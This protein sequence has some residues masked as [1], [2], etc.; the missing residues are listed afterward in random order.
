M[1][2]PRKIPGILIY[3]L[4][5]FFS[6]IGFVYALHAS[7]TQGNQTVYAGGSNSKD[8]VE[9]SKNLEETELENYFDITLTVKTQT[10]IEEI[11][12]AQ[13]IAV[14]I[15]MDISNTMD[16]KWDDNG[17]STPRIDTAQ[18]SAIDFLAEFKTAAAAAPTAAR[19]V[20]F[21][22]FNRSAYEVFGLSDC[23][24]DTQFNN[25]SQK[26]KAIDT[27]DSSNVF[28]TNMEAGLARADKMLEETEIKNKYIIFITDG[29]PTTYSTEIGGT[30]GY[31][32]GTSVGNVT[33]EAQD[34]IFYNYE[35]PS[36]V[37]SGTNYSDRATSRAEEQALKIRNKGITIYSIGIGMTNRQTMQELIE[38][39]YYILDTDT[40]ENNWEY[41][42]NESP[43]KV[44]R[45]YGI[46]PGVTKKYEECNDTEKNS[47]YNNTTYYKTWL[48]DY[49]GSG[50]YYDS[51]AGAQLAQAYKDIFADIKEMSEESSQAT[52]VA[53]D[54]MGVDGTVESIEFVGFLD[55]TNALQN[56]LNIKNENQSDTATISNNKINWDLKN[57]KYEPST[58]EDNITYYTYE[59]KYRV[60]IQNELDAFNLTRVYD[61]NGK[62]TLTYVTRNNGVL[63]D[64]KEIDF[65]IPSV[66]A[67][68]GELEFTKK[69]ASFDVIESGALAGAEFTL[70][71]SSNCPCLVETMTNH[72]HMSEDQSYTATSGTD[73]K[74]SFEN[75]PSGHKY[76]LKEVIAPDNYIASSKQYSVTVAYGETTGGPDDG[77][78]ENTIQKGNLKISKEVQGNKGYKGE[79][80]FKIVI[81][82]NNTTLTG[83][84]NY[85]LY[86]A[87]TKK[88]TTG[89]L[90][91]TDTFKLKDGDYIIIEG[92]PIGSKYKITELTTNGYTVKNKINDGDTQTGATASCSSD[93][94]SINN[95]GTQTVEFYNIAGYILPATGN[96]GMLILLIIVA[97][98]LIVPIINIGYMFYKNRKEDK[99][100]S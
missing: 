45:Y 94:C 100:T 22:T 64:N 42:S 29:L 76:I 27:P 40:E 54:P 11:M 14:V 8:G 2:Q 15:V 36:Y 65:P 41:Y 10:K 32:P 55:D 4:I 1:K 12:K 60:R 35:H 99:L 93:S 31:Y 96:S 51:D 13:D 92:L 53:E 34:G 44:G 57:S 72:K 85:T 66:V 68:L 16:S 9:V 48:R 25:L 62:T 80:E 19:K 17:V 98:L 67:Y 38:D 91:L 49:I 78:V 70:T 81:T 59:V 43:Y 28:W 30:T 26:I 56:S 6:V 77:V 24:N 95:G 90:K 58:G 97:L 69:N 7:V 39:Y 33:A 75:I 46:L 3:L 50:R 23:E 52:W 74:V 61:T 21:V 63:S 20:G 5:L 18:E 73:G 71:H 83:S 86:D 89:K 88:E 79:F 47:Y 82:Y 87:S 84:Y 37:T